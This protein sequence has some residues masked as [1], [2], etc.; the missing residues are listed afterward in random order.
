M[1]EW[2]TSVSDDGPDAVIRGIPLDDVAEMPFGAA[3]WLILQGEKPSDAERELFEMVLSGM[4]D[5]GVGNP[6]SVAARTV[7]SG[8][9]GM[10]TSVAAGVLALGDQH[11]GAIEDAMAMLQRSAAPATIVEDRLAAGERIP[12][13]GHRVYDDHDPRT[14][15]LVEKARDLGLAGEHVDRMTAIRDAFAERKVDL[16]INVDGGVAAVLSDLGWDPR[17]GKGIFIIARAPGLVAQ[18]REEMD[19]PPFRRQDGEYVGE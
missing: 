2:E 5:H 19:E 1:T 8:G 3:I 12:G 15:R 11:G 17:V 7:Q 10:N 18:V 16:V 4:I 9:N 13:L 14:R 6:S